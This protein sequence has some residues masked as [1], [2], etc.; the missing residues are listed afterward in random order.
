MLKRSDSVK[1]RLVLMS[2]VTPGRSGNVI[3]EVP[4]S[5]PTADIITIGGHL[6]SWDLGTGA[7]DD[8]VGVAITTAAAKRIMDAGKPVRTIRVV[9]F[10]A[11]EVGLIGGRAY[12]KA[13]AAEKHAFLAESDSGAGRIYEYQTTVNEAALPTLE[14]LGRALQRLG[15]AKGGNGRASGS[16]IIPMAR[17][18]VP[19]LELSNDLT[20]YYELHHTPDDT[21]DKVDPEDLRHHVAA[22]TTMLAILANDAAELGPVP[23]GSR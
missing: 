7:H 9:W 22:W 8:A 18:G 15:I 6:D 17:T 10:G 11:E 2:K 20:R 14:P 3:A 19:V 21:L 12:A 13:H 1:I 4:G 16:D 23:A 5:D